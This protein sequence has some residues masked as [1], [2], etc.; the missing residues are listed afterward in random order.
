LRDPFMGNPSLDRY[1]MP[2]AKGTVLFEEGQPGDCIQSFLD[3]NGAVRA[4]GMLRSL[5]LPAGGESYR[6]LPP[7][8]GPQL[9]AARAGLS[10]SEAQAVWDRL[11]AAGVLDQAGPEAQLAP[12]SMIEDYRAYLQ[13][14]QKYDPLTVRELSEMTGL[15]EDE[16]H[17]VIRRVL[18]SRLEARGVSGLEDSYQHYLTLKKRFEYLNRV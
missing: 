10:L 4:I 6:P 3:E 8:V 2:F 17:R 15:A 11:R 16:I 7:G 5:A 1:L 13:L 18:S 14:K 12:D 9:F